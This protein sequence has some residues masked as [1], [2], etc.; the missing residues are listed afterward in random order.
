MYSYFTEAKVFSFVL[1]VGPFFNNHSLADVSLVYSE[2]IK[3]VVGI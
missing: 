3:S 1:S 2:N